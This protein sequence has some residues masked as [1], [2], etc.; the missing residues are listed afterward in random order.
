MARP[1][2]WG[3]RGAARTALA[4]AFASTSACG[5]ALGLDATGSLGFDRDAGAAKDGV[6]GTSPDAP[7]TMPF[8]ASTDA[9]PPDAAADAE[10]DGAPDTVVPMDAPGPPVDTGSIA[11]TSATADSATADSSMLP[12]GDSGSSH[13]ARTLDTGTTPADSGTVHDSTSG[14]DGNGGGSPYGVYIN[15]SAWHGSESP[16]GR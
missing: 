11:D 7:S 5:L 10:I 3:M 14:T 15:Q 4:V 12:G 8:D 1:L 6:G 16:G 2:A 13:D 9:R